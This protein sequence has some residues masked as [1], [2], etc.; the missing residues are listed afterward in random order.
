[1]ISTRLLGLF[2]L[3]CALSGCATVFEGTHQAIT[4]NTN[5]AGANCTLNRSP[6]GVI[7]RVNRTPASVT[8]KKTKYDMTIKCYKPGYEEATYLNHSG[9]ALATF[10]DAVIGGATAWAVDSALGADNKYDGA[11]NVTLV[12]SAR[13]FVPRPRAQLQPATPGQPGS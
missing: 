3:A 2:G 12:P 8:I 1:M 5:P 6:E 7:A 13:T 10:G 9:A 11:V 4:V